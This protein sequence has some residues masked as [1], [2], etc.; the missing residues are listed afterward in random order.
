ML[1]VLSGSWLE[2][3]SGFAD[4]LSGYGYLIAV[5]MGLALVFFF[6][7]PLFRT[8]PLSAAEQ[9]AA[10]PAQPAQRAV[11]VVD[12]SA[13]VRAKLR[14]LL[15]S[16]GYRVSVAADGLEAEEAL[17]RERVHLLI[18]DLEMP[19]MDGFALIASVKGSLATETL[20]I[21]AITGH[22]ALQGR[23]RDC[24]GVYGIFQKPW[25]DRELLRRVAALTQLSEL[26]WQLDQGAPAPRAGA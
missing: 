24:E 11:L 4:I 18:T 17:A 13:V 14:K 6:T 22:E 8:Q 1:N 12:D 16:S 21:I 5:L 10:V 23:V 3:W 19:R 26:T 25:S 9:R 15:E 20:P 7:A 2:G